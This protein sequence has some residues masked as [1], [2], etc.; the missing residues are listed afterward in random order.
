MNQSK[1]EKPRFLR[2]SKATSIAK[3]TAVYVILIILCLSFIIPYVWMI[4]TSLRTELAYNSTGFTLLPLDENGRFAF[5][6]ENYAEA[7]A[8]LNLGTVFLNTMLVCV[9]NTLANLFFNSLAAY[10]FARLKFFGRNAIFKVCLFSMMVPGTIMLVPNYLICDFLGITDS[11]TALI[12]PFLMSIY[13]I[14][15]LRQQFLGVDPE[16]EDAARIDGAS[17]FRIYFRIVLPLVKPMLI[18]LGI[19]TFMWNY[20]NYLWPYIVNSDPSLRT[21]STSLAELMGA[22]YD[23]TVKLAGAVIVSAPMIILFFVLQKFIIGGTM[24]GAVKG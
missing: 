9:L 6:F 23:L 13:N 16:I 19:T 3:S 21:L 22:D 4:V 14:F 7:F 24:E 2:G 8:A 11:L 1:A 18:V 17:T 10:A 20:S 5:H 15:L 12:M